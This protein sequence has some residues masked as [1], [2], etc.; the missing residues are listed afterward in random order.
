MDIKDVKVGMK[1]KLLGKHGACDNYNNINDWFKNCNKLEDVQ[2]I[3]EQG[4]GVVVEIGKCEVVWVS[5]CV[6]NTSWC[7]LPSDLEPYESIDELDQTKPK[8]IPSP[9][10]DVK[11]YDKNN[12]V[13]FEGEM[14]LSKDDK[15]SVVEIKDLVYDIENGATIVYFADGTKKIARTEE[16]TEFD[17][18]VGLLECLGKK[19]F[20]NRG[21]LLKVIESGK[22]IKRKKNKPIKEKID[23]AKIS[24]ENVFDRFLKGY[25]IAINCETEEE[26]KELFTIL[27][28]RGIKWIDGGEL[29]KYETLWEDYKKDTSY[30]NIKNGLQFCYR[31]WYGAHD[32]EIVKFKDIFQ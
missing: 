29:S 11:I 10:M 13:I 27:K 26:A 17:K 6:D 21:G 16:G 25:K 30:V 4:F 28:G 5:D 12:K 9:T 8:Y 24:D 2:Q 19:L 23:N 1:V 15:K 14:D 32:F 18:E 7:F 31:E 20:G 22:V 3:K